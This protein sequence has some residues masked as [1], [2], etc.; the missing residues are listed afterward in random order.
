M[1]HPFHDEDHDLQARLRALPDQRMPPPAVWDGIRA[2]I[3][4]AP[5]PAARPA[6]AIAPVARRPATRRRWR[7]PAS[8]AAAASLAALAVLLWPSRMSMPQAPAPAQVAQAPQDTPLLAQADALSL[9]YQRAMAT[10]PRVPTPAELQPA[11]HTLDQ[12]EAQIRDA[13]RQQPDAGYLLGQ[14]RRTYDKRLELTRMA[15]LALPASAT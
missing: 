10:L 8:L 1:N 11:L 7:L 9:E 13:L 3:G 12:S 15:A 4:E 6:L 2:A 14:L 5:A